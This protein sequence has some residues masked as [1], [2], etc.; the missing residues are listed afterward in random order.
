MIATF[1]VRITYRIECGAPDCAERI[2]QTFVL[3]PYNDIPPCVRPKGWH[4]VDMVAYCPRHYVSIFTPEGASD[5]TMSFSQVPLNAPAT[6]LRP[7][8]V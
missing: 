3:P 5:N 7:G 4:V 1:S 6:A 8:C 2:D